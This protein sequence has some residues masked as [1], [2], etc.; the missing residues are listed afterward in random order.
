MMSFFIGDNSGIPVLGYSISWMKIIG[1]VTCLVNRL[2]VPGLDCGHF[3]ATHHGRNGKGRS[4]LHLESSCGDVTNWL[5]AFQLEYYFGGRQLKD[6]S[7][8][9]KLGTGLS[10]IDNNQDIPT[11]GKL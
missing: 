10:I 8:L 1:H 2:H 7:P 6:L 11:V 3:P 4:F 5:T 9:S